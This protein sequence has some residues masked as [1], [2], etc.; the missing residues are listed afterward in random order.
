MN[1]RI[2]LL[3][4]L[5]EWNDSVTCVMIYI[6][7]LGNFCFFG[8]VLRGKLWEWCIMMDLG[9][10]SS[11]K[12]EC[13][14]V[15]VCFGVL[16]RLID[17]L[18][19]IL[20]DSCTKV[21]MFVRSIIVAGICHWTRKCNINRTETNLWIGEVEASTSRCHSMT[22]DQLATQSMAGVTFT[23]DRTFTI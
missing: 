17:Y 7:V 18:P 19:K 20:T 23:T 8:I 1:W 22:F 15:C 9:A 21:F 10:L 4:L 13:V 2:Y 3:D 12:C 14:S 16:C 5:I 11:L 6:G